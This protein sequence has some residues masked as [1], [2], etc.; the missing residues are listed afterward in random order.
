MVKRFRWF[1]WLELACAAACVPLLFAF[2]RMMDL[3]HAIPA[4]YSNRSPAPIALG[5]SI[6]AAVYITVRLMFVHLGLVVTFPLLVIGGYVVIGAI[7]L[8]LGG[9]F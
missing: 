1:P 9:I 3:K 8:F 7:L 6:V 5:L 4:S 2:S